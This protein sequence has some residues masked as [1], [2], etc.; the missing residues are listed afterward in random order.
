MEMA[1]AIILLALI[2]YMIFSARVGWA[3][4]K[5]GVS[6][7]KTTG[8]ETFERIYRVQINTLEQLIIFIPATV[9]F[10]IY[11]HNF[12]VW[13]PGVAFLVGRLW[14]ARCYEH[15]PEKRAPGMVL[16]FLANAIMVLWSLVMI[17]IALLNHG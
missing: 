16:G 7:P 3:R 10:S 8:D 5:Y 6:A 12:W 1:I 2:Q 13:V 4:G 17:S 11:V 15:A 14:F 9:A